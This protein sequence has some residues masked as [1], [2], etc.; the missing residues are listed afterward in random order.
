MDR[1]SREATWLEIAGVISNRSTCQRTHVGVVLVVDRRILITGYNGSPTGLP[2][3]DGRVDGNGSC[4]SC[5][6]A[7]A[8]AIAIAAKQGVKTLG[9]EM[10][11]THSPC[12][13][14]ARLL[15][16]AGIKQVWYL[17]CYHSS[18]LAIKEL[19]KSGVIV[20]E[21]QETGTLEQ[22]TES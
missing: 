22:D 6:H 13:T 2:H 18:G 15:I 19:M 8:N 11:C 10:Y 14:C 9:A 20:S 21:Y 4:I 16:N 5:V 3:C 12:L 1:P 7:E 17:N